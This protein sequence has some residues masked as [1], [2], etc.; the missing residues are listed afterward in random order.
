MKKR[1]P[2]RFAIRG[3]SQSP[4]TDCLVR[5]PAAAVLECLSSISRSDKQTHL[6]NTPRQVKTSLTARTEENIA[7]DRDLSFQP[8]T[9]P[10][11]SPVACP[12]PLFLPDVTPSDPA[13]IATRGRQQDGAS[14][15]EGGKSGLHRKHPIWYDN[16]CTHSHLRQLI[17]HLQVSV[18]NRSAKSL[19]ARA[20]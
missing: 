3:T 15:R 1:N 12:R 2:P 8:R 7:L 11:K 5:C 14:T 17:H 9:T 16:N 4:G 20:P 18:K 10:S 13:S 6:L 19:A